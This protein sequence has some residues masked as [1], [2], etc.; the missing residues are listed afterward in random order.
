MYYGKHVS[1]S[2]VIWRFIIELKCDSE[3]ER[4]STLEMQSTTRLLIRS[5][6]SDD[7]D[8]ITKF[9]TVTR[10]RPYTSMTGNFSENT[11]WRTVA[12]ATTEKV[13]CIGSSFSK[14][15]ETRWS[16]QHHRP[17]KFRNFELR[18]VNGRHFY[19]QKSSSSYTMLLGVAPKPG[20]MTLMSTQKAMASSKFG[21]F[22]RLKVFF[23]S[24]ILVIKRRI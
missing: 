22:R 24:Y 19:I 12:I 23:W 10:T 3:T 13:R 7:W 4:M 9:F 11:R 5:T 15:H 18:M 16:S 17:L 8:F 1:V 21:T 14:S 20:R 6:F 2:A